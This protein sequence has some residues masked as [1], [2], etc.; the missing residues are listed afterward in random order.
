MTEEIEKVRKSNAGRKPKTV[1]RE[2]NSVEKSRDRR[3][4]Q[5][6][7][8]RFPLWYLEDI[9]NHINELYYNKEDNGDGIEPPNISKQ[10]VFNELAKFRDRLDKEAIDDALTLRRL[11]IA[12]YQE[13][14]EY[15]QERFEA[16]VGTHTKTVTTTGEKDSTRTEEEDLAGEHPFL[17]LKKACMDKILELEG[18]LSPRKTALTDP[19]G[20]KPFDAFGDSEE[21][22]RL[23]AIFGEITKGK[24]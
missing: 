4:M 9:A 17:Q 19:T 7:R 3:L 18:S 5:R 6:L 21:L 23:A 14:A 15:C 11:R 1:R 12:Q 22:K 20:T 2:R 24:A 8:L 10:M 13:L 16:T